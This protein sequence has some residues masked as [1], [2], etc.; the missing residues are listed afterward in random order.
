M[1][2]WKESATEYG[3]RMYQHAYK[4]KKK[5]LNS[6][7][8]SIALNKNNAL[9]ID[10]N[11]YV[12]QKGN[13]AM[14]LAHGTEQGGIQFGDIS[15]SPRAYI[16][17]LEDNGVLTPD[18]KKLYTIDCYGGKQKSFISPGGIKVSSS[19]T[20]QV[21]I[22]LTGFKDKRGQ[23]ALISVDKSK[24]SF[25]E[26]FQR[27]LES[28][29]L[30]SH[31]GKGADVKK[32][33]TQNSKLFK[34][35]QHINKLDGSTYK[36]PDKISSTMQKDIDVLVNYLKDINGTKDVEKTL[37]KYSNE[38]VIQNRVEH[39]KDIVNGKTKASKEVIDVVSK[40]K[41]VIRASKYNFV[42]SNFENID[43]SV[44][45][46]FYGLEDSLDAEFNKIRKKSTPTS[47]QAVPTVSEAKRVTAE[48]K[49]KA[50]VK[51]KVQTIQNTQATKPTE[52]IT[53]RKN[54][55]DIKSHR[56][57][58]FIFTPNQHQ[59]NVDKIVAE[60]L[61]LQQQKTNTTVKNTTVEELHTHK[62]ILQAKQNKNVVEQL[63]NKND[64]AQ[65][66]RQLEIKKVN[67]PTVQERL[68]TNPKID[69]RGHGN[70]SMTQMVDKFNQTRQ[71]DVVNTTKVSKA[72]ID[73]VTDNV[74][75]FA[76]KIA[77]DFSQFK[78]GKVISKLF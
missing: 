73:T 29:G 51:P 3:R 24:G 34:D 60:Q 48:I 38:K 19:H 15:M 6:D 56:N 45:D 52:A 14:L 64:I 43:K 17:I 59:I 13:M 41:S 46:F 40:Y 7:I 42:A 21:P 55:I 44:S 74:D 47:T 27:D 61:A 37:S 72:V 35:W 4:Q 1:A 26:S 28:H 8:V 30:V 67:G 10:E 76:M 16:K 69:L 18:I 70:L 31:H 9:N 54:L 58:Q 49:P 53:Y 57:N 71:V 68:N 78:Y 25:S 62:E 77:A 65:E 22:M 2:F 32:I 39:F 5:G 23:H 66:K 75:E 50:E 36:R 12:F 11:I 33:S 20:A 63:K